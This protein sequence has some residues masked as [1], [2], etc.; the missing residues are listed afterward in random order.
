MDGGM[1]NKLVQTI[2]D[3]DAAIV[4]DERETPIVFATWFGEPTEDLVRRFYQWQS[5]MLDRI[6]ATPSGKFVFITDSSSAGRPTPKARKLITDLLSEL[7]PKIQR[8]TLR[9][10]IVIDNPL[11]RGVFTAL[12]WLNPRMAETVVSSSCAIAIEQAFQDLDLAG[13]PRPRGL[14][15]TT[16]RRPANPTR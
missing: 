8:Y 4:L 6:A 14:T 12:A 9:A 2:V 7:E 13:V 10:Y 15:A 3:G 16:Y 11:I 5:K 1:S